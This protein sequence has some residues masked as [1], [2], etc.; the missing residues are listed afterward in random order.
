MPSEPSLLSVES[1]ADRIWV[2]HE[3]ESIGVGFSGRWGARETLC[4]TELS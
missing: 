4:L 1:H 2:E 3:G